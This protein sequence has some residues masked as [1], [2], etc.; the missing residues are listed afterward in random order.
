MG[1]YRS[2]RDA[3]LWVEERGE[4]DA[5]L[6]LHGGMSDVDEFDSNLFLLADRFRV[7]GYDRRG[8]GRSADTG[9]FTMEAMAD[10]A[11]ALI[12]SVAG[13]L[14][15]LVGYS[16]GGMVA[17][18]V[19]IR[20]PDLVSSLTIISS[21][22]QADDWIVRPQA[23]ADDSADAGYP[24]VIVDRYAQL[25]PDGREHFPIL[26]R[27]AAELAAHDAAPADALTSYPGRALFVTADDDFVTLE[28]QIAL[29][30][31]L[32]YGE[33]AVVPGTSHMLLLEKPRQVTALV[34]DFLENA[35]LVPFAPIGRAGS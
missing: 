32:R 20:R 11:S 25:S 19:A 14:A 13:G 27:K 18:L 10:D 7:I 24:A 31:S 6:L 26:V 3:S 8:F 2:I 1:E 16:A 23:P 34:R 22:L 33:L 15:H 30:R 17:A 28:S 5:V 12:E 21:A 9:P 4:G 35:P 29:Y